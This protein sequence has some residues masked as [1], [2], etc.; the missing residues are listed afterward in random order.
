MTESPRD[1]R[2]RVVRANPDARDAARIND[3]EPLRVPPPEPTPRR[4][5][6]HPLVRFLIAFAVT[7]GFGIYVSQRADAAP[8]AP[9]V[10]PITSTKVTIPIRGGVSLAGVVVGPS[11]GSWP[12]LVMP[13]TFAAGTDKLQLIAEQL[14]PR[15]YTIVA[16]N[17]RGFGASGGLVDAGGASDVADASDVLDWSLT[18]TTGRGDAVGIMSLSYGSGFLPM[19]IARDH[20]FR[21]AAM[22]SGWG[23]M[24]A[25]LHPNDTGARASNLIFKTLASQHRPSP[26]VTAFFDRAV[27]NEFPESSRRFASERSPID[28]LDEIRTNPVPL[29]MSTSM[30]EM[31]W[32]LDQTIDLFDAYPGPKHLDVLPGDHA[33][34]EVAT[35]FGVTP[36]TWAAALD[37]FDVH[38][39]KRPAPSGFA[40]PIRVVPRGPSSPNV[41]ST[42][43]FTSWPFEGLSSFDPP[44]TRRTWL[45]TTSSWWGLAQ[46][47][48]LS[49]TPGPT[50][51][52][53][54][55]GSN[56]LL[57][58]GIPMYQGIFEIMTGAPTTVPLALVDQNVAGVWKGPRVSAPTRLRGATAVH[59]DLTPSASTGSV[60][61]YLLSQAP[62]GTTS[63][64]AHKPFTYRGAT[65]GRAT[66]VD[67]DIPYQAFNVPTGHRLVIA[68]ATDDVLYSSN[69]VNR[70]T[71]R[72]NPGSYADLPIE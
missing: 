10:P 32:P 43:R 13:G 23:D 58:G 7:I 60:F 70:S 36:A 19:V 18:H 25:A 37:W 51:K 67:L 53:L 42:D 21:A 62:D 72:I 39:M 27:R 44:A 64:L 24:W 2:L 33:T 38:L 16:Y 40:D 3:R 11:S 14:A 49:P 47:T 30:N 4:G 12:L 45:S 26:E 41:I 55:S 56:L 8:V 46:T 31:I 20:R 9:T 34:S 68:V 65:P 6:G 52:T 15:G 48:T 17:E 66:T 61:V 71:V 59:L 57:T 22:L 54:T 35:A 5:I 29:Y 50:S 1:R 69:T 63:F 28:H